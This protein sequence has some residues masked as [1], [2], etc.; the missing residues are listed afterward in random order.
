M[1]TLLMDNPPFLYT[2]F[3]IRT[4]VSG[5]PREDDAMEGVLWLFWFGA[6]LFLVSCWG[7]LIT[8]RPAKL[9]EE[10][11]TSPDESA[12]LWGSQ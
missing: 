2:I 9:S 4:R 3:S 11:G 1:I 10:A 12:E 5:P 7:L 6:G 8:F